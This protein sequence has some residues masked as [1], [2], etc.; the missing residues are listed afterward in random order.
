MEKKIIK[1]KIDR[2]HQEEMNE[3]RKKC[4]FEPEPI[5]PD[6]ELEALFG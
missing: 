2:K 6:Y 5:K 4:G 1:I 3:I